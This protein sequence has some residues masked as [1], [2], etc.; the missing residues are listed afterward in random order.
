MT[1]N[2]KNIT[3]PM[4]EKNE[5]IR[6]PEAPKKKKKKSY[7]SLMRSLTKSSLTEKQRIQ[8]QKERINQ[9]FVDVNF[10][11]VDVI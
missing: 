10:K 9:S 11:K 2:N 4:K 7:K 8:K 5:E 1:E 6:V 3:P